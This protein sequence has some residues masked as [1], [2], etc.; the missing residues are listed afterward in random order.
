MARQLPDDPRKRKLQIFKRLYQHLEHFK[1]LQRRAV[2][3]L[4]AS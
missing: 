1:S 4:T 3:I 2:L